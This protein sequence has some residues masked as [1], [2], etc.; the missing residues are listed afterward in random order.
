VRFVSGAK[1]MN[2]D[3]IVKTF[4]PLQVI[5]DSVTYEITAA[6][7]ATL[8]VNCGDF[9]DAHGGNVKCLFGS[10][11]F[12]PA[13]QSEAV[14]LIQEARARSLGLFELKLYDFDITKVLEMNSVKDL[15]LDIDKWTLSDLAKASE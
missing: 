1:A 12:R 3:R 8:C 9:V 13:T 6:Q 11:V 4:Q 2:V 7:A 5:H 14:D 10:T 15:S